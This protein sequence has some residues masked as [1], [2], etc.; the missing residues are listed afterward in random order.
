[1][2]GGIVVVDKENTYSSRPPK[3]VV[4]DL[5]MKTPRSKRIKLSEIP[6]LILE[7]LGAEEVIKK[8]ITFS[9]A[10]SISESSFSFVL[11]F[12][13]GECIFF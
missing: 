3:R 4:S 6:D 9:Q 13:S 12:Q 1:M 5:S 2:L 8:L 11:D 10:I 7:N